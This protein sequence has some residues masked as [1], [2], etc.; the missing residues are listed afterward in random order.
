MK[1]ENFLSDKA[2]PF[3]KVLEIIKKVCD[4]KKFKIAVKDYYLKN[5]N[6]SSYSIFS[7]I[8]I[9]ECKSFH[10]QYLMKTINPLADSEHVMIIN[11]TSGPFA[12]IS[13]MDFSRRF[14]KVLYY[15][16]PI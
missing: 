2:F 6:M 5:V 7:T 15:K 13:I 12:H 16:T 11:R 4:A 9:I 10:G 14:N 1:Y 8:E 3:Y